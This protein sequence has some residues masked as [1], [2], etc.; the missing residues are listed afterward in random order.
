MIKKSISRVF[1]VIVSIAL[2]QILGT[3]ILARNLTKDEMGLFRIILTIVDLGS[4]SCL[5][6]M[7][8]AFVRFFSS[9]GVS[10]KEYNWKSFL[11]KLSGLSLLILI[12]GTLVI[13]GFFHL[14]PFVVAGTV[15]AIAMLAVVQML[16]ACSRAQQKYEL[17]IT[18]SR[19]HFVV[20]F[21]ILLFLQHGGKLTFHNV[22][23]GFLIAVLAALVAVATTW[24]SRALS[25]K[26]P[27]P[28]S[29]VKNGFYYFGIGFSTLLLLQFNYLLIGK[30]LSYRALAVY[31]VTAS[32]M[33]LFEFIQ[34]A[35]YYI[36]APH[37]N[38]SMRLPAQ[39]I[40]VRLFG[41]GLL[42]ALFYVFFGQALIHFLL[43]GRYDEG[44]YLLPFFIITGVLRILYVVPVSL[45]GGRSSEATLRNQFRIIIVA[46]ILNIG[47]SYAFIRLWGLAGAAGASIII[48]ALLLGATIIG[49]KHDFI[50][51]EEADFA[52]TSSS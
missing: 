16:A 36:L 51:T 15:A 40:F 5:A 35:T 13:E 8:H 24:G 7:D 27:I 3:I 26:I 25:G 30:M 19:L 2:L 17:A 18:F 45:I 4:L 47:L 14:K 34:D 29:V 20:F 28:V 10:F 22:I 12:L 31:S 41:V 48:W 6:G 33:R 46:V 38:K 9:P 50:Q 21:I 1:I 49:T 39:K 52:A 43:K 32:V 42:A 11:K 23:L 37:L 44:F